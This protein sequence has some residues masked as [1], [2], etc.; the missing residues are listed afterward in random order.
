MTTWSDERIQ[1]DDRYYNYERN[2]V[3]L[4]NILYIN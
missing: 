3:M 1:M 2:Y 4:G